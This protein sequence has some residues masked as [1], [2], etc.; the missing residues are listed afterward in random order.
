MAVAP[1]AASAATFTVTK[2]ADT[3]DG[4]C[5]PTNCS[6]RDAISAANALGGTNSITLPAG[7][8]SLSIPGTAET[9][10]ATGDLDVA[11]S[12]NLNITGVGAR[13]TI[14][15]GAGIDRV[16]QVLNG[17]TLNMSGVTVTGGVVHTTGSD[18]AGGGIE[19][20]HAS[21]IALS[22]VSVSGNQAEHGGGIWI[23]GALDLT[24]VLVSNNTALPLTAQAGEGGG[25]NTIG[26]AHSTLTDVTITGN[27]AQQ[28][29]TAG[30]DGG[31]AT[32]Y[33][34]TLVNVTIAGNSITASSHGE[35][36]GLESDSSVTV[37]NTIVAGNVAGSAPDNCTG[38]VS[39]SSAYDLDSGT[40][41]GFTG[42]GDLQNANPMLGA[43]ANNGGP[44]DTLALSTG[45]P[46]IDAATN[47]GCP[48]VDQ[49]GVA[50]PQGAACD[51]GAYEYVPQTTP[52]PPPPPPSPPTNTVPPKVTGTPLPGDHLSCSDGSWTGSPSSFAF[53]WNRGGKT[54][55]GANSSGYTVQILDEAQT[56]SCTVTATNSGGSTSAT[57]PGVLVAQPGT[58]HCP[59]P[60]GKLSGTQLGPFKLGMTRKHARHLLKHWHLAYYGLDDYCFYGG[61]GIRVGYPSNLLRRE[62]KQAAADAGRIVLMLS[63]N[64]F[65]TFDGLSAGIPIATAIKRLHLGKPFHVGA[66]YWYIAAGKKANIVI[67]SGHGF[68]AEIGLANKQLTA[69]PKQQA[70][71]LSSFGR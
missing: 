62:N 54:L 50:R 8:Y 66:N 11:A 34:A 10:N 33:N 58:L 31:G 5:A 37:A 68:I 52:P 20:D 6:L 32:L 48:A 46:A 56:L 3:N 59:R 45:S 13:T 1:A 69:T 64:P 55:S 27:Q 9:A 19:G 57:S 36:G 22:D 4:A 70:T 30:S 43:L 24:R 49:R 51:I 7:H 39:T 61:W 41:C 44:T 47:T 63:A 71:F 28:G 42:T 65:W 29:F 23:D 25:I 17:A 14:I 38:G 16:F 15:D 60:F 21:T 2:T 18:Y 12:T 53:R 67:K 26:S 40:D 35:G